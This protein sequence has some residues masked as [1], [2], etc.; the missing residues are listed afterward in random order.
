MLNFLAH[1]P[2]SLIDVQ[3]KYL[4]VENKNNS[5]S[6]REHLNNRKSLKC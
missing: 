1:L 2:M 5:I 4:V 3:N 6:F